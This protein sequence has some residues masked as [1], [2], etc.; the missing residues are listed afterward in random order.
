MFSG[1]C[2]ACGSG[3]RERDRKCRLCGQENPAMGGASASG[4]PFADVSPAV[5]TVVAAPT[6]FAA[7][8][9]APPS[10][11]EQRKAAQRSRPFRPA[12]PKPKA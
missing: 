10:I 8:A 2:S 11:A 9:L 5:E 6:S 12:A 3:L 4:S 7:A 1:E